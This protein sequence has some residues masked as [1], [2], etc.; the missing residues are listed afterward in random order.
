MLFEYEIPTPRQGC[1]NVTTQMRE[2]LRKSHIGQGLCTVYCPHTTAG[3]VI[4]E[5]G[6]TGV[7]ADFMT[8]ME[9]L[10]PKELPYAHPDKDA[11]AHMKA[12]LAG[13]SISVPVE[14]GN[15]IFGN[16]QSLYLYRH[17]SPRNFCG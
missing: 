14:N 16:W 1:V 8:A 9:R 3:V 6:D 7:H 17:W 11:A 13:A 12:A 5:N 2:A 10:C 15:L 4:M